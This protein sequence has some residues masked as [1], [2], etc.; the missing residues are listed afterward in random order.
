MTTVSVVM[1]MSSTILCAHDCCLSYDST[2]IFLHTF[3]G[4]IDSGPILRHRSACYPQT[5]T[6]EAFYILVQ[7]STL[8]TTI[9]V[10]GL[11]CSGASGS[12]TVNIDCAQTASLIFCI[13]ALDLYKAFANVRECA[14]QSLPTSDKLCA[15]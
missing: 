15:S 2:H 11:C 9:F 8:L 1:F 5:L 4:T 10:Y 6:I 13:G 3:S 7:S 12:P 14:S